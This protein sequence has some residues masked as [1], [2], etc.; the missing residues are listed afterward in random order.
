MAK[1]T[2]KQKLSI[3]MVA[4]Y[5]SFASE[6]LKKNG[7]TKKYDEHVWMYVCSRDE[8]GLEVA[9]HERGAANRYW[10]SKQKAVA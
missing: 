8:L 10:Q 4:I 7:L 3:E 1:L 9:E 2:K 5:Y 6:E